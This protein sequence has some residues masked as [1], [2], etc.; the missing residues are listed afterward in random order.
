M[1]RTLKDRRFDYWEDPRPYWQRPVMPTGSLKPW[2]RLYWKSVR[3]RVRLA[4][5]RG[6]EPEPTRTRG[7]IKWDVW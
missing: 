6:D 4:L 3:N 2:Q 5:H 1:A 7:S